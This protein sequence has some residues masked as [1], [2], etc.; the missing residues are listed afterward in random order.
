M[1]IS[2]WYPIT[3]LI[4]TIVLGII[5]SFT[6]NKELIGIRE[7]EC[8]TQ[9]TNN[10]NCKEDK[11]CCTMWNDGKCYIGKSKYL[12]EC[13]LSSSMI[14]RVISWLTLSFGASFIIILIIS[15]VQHTSKK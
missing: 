13:E 4:I 11:Q 5:A 14:S 10:K 15:I 6:F 2:Y 8:G 12:G 3:L 7:S 9:S 1:I